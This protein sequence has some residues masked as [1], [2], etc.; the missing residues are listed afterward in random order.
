VPGSEKHQFKEF[1]V[2]IQPDD[3]YSVEEG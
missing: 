2:I 3:R 1:A